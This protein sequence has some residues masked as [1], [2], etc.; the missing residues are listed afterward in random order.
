MPR[1]VA[2]QPH[3]GQEAAEVPVTLGVVDV[4]RPR[5]F[6]VLEYPGV[7]HLVIALANRQRPECG[8]VVDDLLEQVEHRPFGRSYPVPPG[9]GHDRQAVVI[10]LGHYGRAGGGVPAAVRD[11]AVGRPQ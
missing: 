11:S 7:Q 6:G 3:S 5:L 10:G 1:D 9:G 8:F 4:L 2:R